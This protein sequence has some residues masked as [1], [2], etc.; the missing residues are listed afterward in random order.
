[1]AGRHHGLSGK[2]G[3]SACDR[4]RLER[5]SPADPTAATGPAV[6]AAKH[7]KALTG[8]PRRSSATG[9]SAAARAAAYC[10]DG[11]CGTGP[12]G[13]QLSPGSQ[14]AVA[15]PGR[16]TRGHRASGGWRS[17]VSC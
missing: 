10:T 15:E 16:A 3:E 2:D 7:N 14:P 9:V 4:W 13:E 12:R 1:L 17:A 8:M 5:S 11:S 6:S